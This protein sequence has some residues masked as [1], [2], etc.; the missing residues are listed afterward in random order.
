[1][2]K[3]RTI[4]NM[5]PKLQAEAEAEKEEHGEGRVFLE[6]RSLGVRSCPALCDCVRSPVF[7]FLC[8]L[9]YRAMVKMVKETAGIFP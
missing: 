8:L 7:V 4:K 1:M 3:A 2:K 6:T 5:V 9:V